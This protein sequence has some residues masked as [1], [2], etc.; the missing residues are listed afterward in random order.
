V[1]AADLSRVL[2]DFFSSRDELAAVYLFGSE[3][4]GEARAE[5]DVDLGLLYREPPRATLM[6]Q[7]FSLEA[8][9]SS[10]LGRQVQCVVLNQAPPDLVHRVLRDGKVVCERDRSRRL[11]FEVKARNE[12]FDIRPALLRYRKLAG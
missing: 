11:A 3:A 7:P 2:R 8:E 9:L 5:S 12:Y 4:R 1:P 10:L 6:D